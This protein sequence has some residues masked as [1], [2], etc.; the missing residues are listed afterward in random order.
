M[1]KRKA[2]RY[3]CDFCKKSGCNS[4]CIKEHEASCTFNPNRVCRLCVRIHDGSDGVHQRALDD[5][6]AEVGN[7]DSL[8]SWD[9]DPEDGYNGI[10]GPLQAKPA[11][12]KVR[13]AAQGCPACMLT[14]IKAI[15]KNKGWLEG[16]DFKAE[17]KAAYRDSNP[18]THA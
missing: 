6:L 16:F 5:M 4:A 1:T 15:T 13:A 8:I 3:K 12:D 2:W 18:D 17:S 14:V 9:R 11:L 7:I 10:L